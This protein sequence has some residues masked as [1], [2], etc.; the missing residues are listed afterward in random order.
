[1]SQ[2]NR[3]I[4]FVVEMIDR[5]TLNDQVGSLESVIVSVMVHAEGQGKWVRMWLQLVCY[6]HKKFF[7]ACLFFLL[8]SGFLL[9][10]PFFFAKRQTVLYISAAIAATQALLNNIKTVSQFYCW[11][12]K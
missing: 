7:W 8:F 4:W 11:T 10:R 2:L 6:I 1:M 5:N 3:V 12:F 9:F